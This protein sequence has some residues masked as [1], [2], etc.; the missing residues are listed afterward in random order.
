MVIADE[1]RRPSLSGRRRSTT[2][3]ANRRVIADEHRRPSLSD[4]DCRPGH[5]DFAGSL[6][7]NTVG[8]R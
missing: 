8:L 6:P 5:T 2:R 4:L 1:H 3:E 7:M